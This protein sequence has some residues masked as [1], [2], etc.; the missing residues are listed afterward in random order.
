MSAA[1]SRLG[2][3]RGLA[4]RG[5]WTGGG[6]PMAHWV[7]SLALCSTTRRRSAAEHAEVEDLL[8]ELKQLL[9][10]VLSA[11]ARANAWR[12]GPGC[13]GVGRRRD[14][15]ATPDP[16]ADPCLAR[17]NAHRDRCR[18]RNATLARV[19]HPRRTNTPDSWGTHLLM[20]ESPGIT[21]RASSR[22]ISS[23]NDAGPSADREGLDL[24]TLYRGAMPSVARSHP[25][26]AAG[27]YADLPDLSA[28]DWTR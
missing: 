4:R 8:N 15:S 6:D 13:S 11:R 22:S 28:V 19:A 14:A 1:L 17:G 24:A 20:I 12:T 2:T 25:S 18:S 10:E 26:T 16:G 21:Q 27:S 23:I 3:C 5:W 9:D 7:R